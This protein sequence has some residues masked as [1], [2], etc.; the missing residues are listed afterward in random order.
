MSTPFHAAVVQDAPAAFDLDASVTRALQ[1]LAEAAGQGAQLVVFPEA[2]LSGYPKGLDFG[3]RVGMRS[4]EG[5]DLFRRYYES[6]LEVPGPVTATLGA[7]ARAHR[8]YMVIGVIERAGGTLY[9]TVLFFGPD[10]TLLGTHRKVMP[11]AMERLIWGFGDGST[12]QVLPTP[13]GRIGA[14]ICWEN[15][16]PQLRLALYGQ[17]VQLYCAPTVDDRETWLPTMRHIAL[18]GRCFVL[19]ACQFARRCD[20]P[21]DVTPIQGDDPETVLIRG[22]SCIISPL[23]E[24][25]AGPVFD[26]PALLSA[27]IDI[28]AISRG[29][30]DLDVVGHYARPDLFQL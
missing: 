25:L 12:L 28:G 16:M 24:V 11:T 6:A 3:A 1:R 18:E 13:L 8:V 26:A 5:R 20:F 22:G 30:F 4:P 21:P 23:G 7:A 17:G 27:E 14:A 2:F 9:C 19:S 29:T 15:Y 10:G